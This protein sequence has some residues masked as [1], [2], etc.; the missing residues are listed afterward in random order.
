MRQDH[1]HFILILLDARSCYDRISPP[2]ASLCLQRQGTPLHLVQLMFNTIQEM[3]HFIRTSYGD[4]AEWYQHQTKGFMGFYKA[5]GP[6]PPY[7]HCI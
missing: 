3:Q 2:I 7:G 4:S 1:K 6:A 5:M